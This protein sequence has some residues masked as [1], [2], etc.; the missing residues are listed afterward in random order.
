MAYPL[1][2]SELS[3]QDPIQQPDLDTRHHVTR[4]LE[5]KL[6]R[7]KK[8]FKFHP[9]WQ[10]NVLLSLGLAFAYVGVVRFEASLVNQQKHI[11]GLK[12]ELVEAKTEL[13]YLASPERLEKKAIA[14]LNMRAPQGVLFFPGDL[15]PTQVGKVDIGLDMPETHAGF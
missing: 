9:F 1:L 14:K 11:A 7:T 5:T 8:Q 4:R 15:K 2:K 12:R 6:K 3:Y 13:A 10:V